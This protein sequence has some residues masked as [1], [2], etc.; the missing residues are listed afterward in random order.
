MSNVLSALRDFLARAFGIVLVLWDEEN[1]DPAPVTLSRFRTKADSLPVL[2]HAGLVHR[3]VQGWT[4][5]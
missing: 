1:S 4:A 5:P 3:P 2:A